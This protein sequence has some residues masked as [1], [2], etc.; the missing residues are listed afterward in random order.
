MRMNRAD[1][2]SIAAWMLKHW[3]PVPCG[4]ALAGDLLEEF[5]SEREGRARVWYWRQVLLAIAIG[6]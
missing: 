5:R 1:P 3:T 6:C 4:D 2:P